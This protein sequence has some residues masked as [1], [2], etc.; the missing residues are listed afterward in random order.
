MSGS[1]V[2][3][4]SGIGYP[5]RFFDTLGSLGFDVITHPYPDHYEFSLTELLQYT[6]HP[7][8]VTSKDAVKIRSLFLQAKAQQTQ[9]VD[10]KA[11]VGRSWVLPVTAVLSD[12]CYQ[13]LNE[14]LKTLG[15]FT[16][17]VGNKNKN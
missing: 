5:Q 2:H 7:I 1:Q 14:Q 17:R 10:W 3:A 4:I 6:D 15:I 9:T 8:V 11:L 13:T 16:D 12:S